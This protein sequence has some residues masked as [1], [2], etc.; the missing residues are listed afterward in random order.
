MGFKYCGSN[1][2]GEGLHQNCSCYGAVK[3]LERGMKVMEQ[4]LEKRFHIIVT[5]DEMQVG[6]M[7][8]KGVTDVEF[9]LKGMQEEYLTNGKKLYVFVDLEKVFD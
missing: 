7:P 9:I 8:M 2:Q 6:L 1:L 5:V 4:V 3:L